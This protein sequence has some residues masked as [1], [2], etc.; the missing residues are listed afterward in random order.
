MTETSKIKV[1]V[2]RAIG[3]PIVTSTQ[4]SLQADGVTP[5]SVVGET[6]FDLS[7]ADKSLHLVALV[8]EDLKVDILDGTP[9]LTANDISVRPARH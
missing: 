4:W 7:R 6:R 3:A 9:F 1:S 2:V 5:L 8:V